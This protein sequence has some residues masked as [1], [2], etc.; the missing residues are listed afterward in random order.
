MKRCWGSTGGEPT[1]L[2]GD[3]LWRVIATC[4]DELP[5]TALHIL[6][7][8]RRFA[9]PGFTAAMAAI[10]HPAIT[11]AVPVYADVPD[12]HDHVVQARNAFDETLQGPA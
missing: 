12:V 2:L 10:G 8:G 3:D 1:A 11:W 5:R 4:R 6:S 7:N 9:E